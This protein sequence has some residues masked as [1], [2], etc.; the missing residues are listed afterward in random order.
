MAGSTLKSTQH[1]Q[2]S[3]C[4]G[5]QG[6]ELIGQVAHLVSQAIANKENLEALRDWAAE[7]MDVL[8]EKHV[9]GV[10]SEGGD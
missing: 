9:V 7:L 1:V 2:Q 8:I 6:L 3:T 5:A 4:A 10:L